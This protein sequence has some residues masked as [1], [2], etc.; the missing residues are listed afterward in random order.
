MSMSFSKPP[1]FDYRAHT[2]KKIVEAEV[3]TINV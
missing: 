2:H 3:E 1:G